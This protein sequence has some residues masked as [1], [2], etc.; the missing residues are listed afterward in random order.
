MA[1]MAISFARHRQLR[2]PR[3]RVEAPPPAAS[4][5]V[6]EPAPPMWA[7]IVGLISVVGGLSAHLGLGTPPAHHQPWR[8]ILCEF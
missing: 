4:P 5:P 6:A 7:G 3:V 2:L 8:E 1:R